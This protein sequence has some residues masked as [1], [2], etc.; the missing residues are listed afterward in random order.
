MLGLYAQ[1]PVGYVSM[2]FSVMLLVIIDRI[3]YLHACKPAKVIYHY[4]NLL[5]M[6]LWVQVQ[7]PVVLCAHFDYTRSWDRGSI[8]I[9]SCIGE[10]G[11]WFYEGVP[12]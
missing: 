8:W 5:G 1:L 2:L 7:G 3:I 9:L 10:F 6:C 4:F 12:T 11:S